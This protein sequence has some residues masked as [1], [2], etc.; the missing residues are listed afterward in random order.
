MVNTDDLVRNWLTDENTHQLC[1]KRH[2][3][4]AVPRRR[5]SSHFRRH[6]HG[7]DQLASLLDE[8]VTH[9]VNADLHKPD[10]EESHDSEPASPDVTLVTVRRQDGVEVVI[11]RD[12]A[13][14]TAVRLVNLHDQE[15]VV[16][17]FSDRSMVRLPADAIIAKAGMGEMLYALDGGHS[18]GRSR[19]QDRGNI[20]GNSSGAKIVSTNEVLQAPVFFPPHRFDVHHELVCR[21]ERALA[22][23]PPTTQGELQIVLPQMVNDREVHFALI[24]VNM[25]CWHRD[26]TG[27]TLLLLGVMLVAEAFKRHAAEVAQGQGGQQRHR[28]LLR[29]VVWDLEL[30]AERCMCRQ[31]R[32]TRTSTTMMG[33]RTRTTTTT[34]TTVLRRKSV[35]LVEEERAR[36]GG[37]I[38]INGQAEKEIVMSDDQTALADEEASAEKTAPPSSPSP[39]SAGARA[40][41]A[42]AAATQAEASE[43]VRRPQ[44]KVSDVIIA[45]TRRSLSMIATAALMQEVEEEEE[46]KEEVV[47]E[48]E[49]VLAA[50]TTKTKITAAADAMAVRRKESMDVIAVLAALGRPAVPLRYLMVT[51]NNVQKAQEKWEAT[52]KWRA[53]YR[54]DTILEAPHTQ[55]HFIKKYFPQFMAGRSRGGNPVYY[56]M[57]AK[58]DARTLV[59]QGVDVDEMI[60]HY[61]W[62]NEF[63]YSRWVPDPDGQIITVVDISGLSM[64]GM[65][66][67][68]IEFISRSLTLIQAHYPARAQVILLVNAPFFFSYIWKIVKGAADEYTSNT[69][70]VFS[71]AQ[72]FSALCEYI[73]PDQ[74]PVEY[75]GN[76]R[77]APLEGTQEW[78]K[79]QEMPHSVRWTSPLEREMEE[80]VHRVIAARKGGAMGK[81][82]GA[83]EEEV[84]EGSAAVGAA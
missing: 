21:V 38:I 10:E 39:S 54:A 81:E 50:T 58:I 83:E 77:Y 70:K 6:S 52:L 75:G 47:D 69:L 14:G 65:S 62:I 9:S 72:T 63:I 66:T 57:N 42:S 68:S 23:A 37:A 25:A 18:R 34:T 51:G 55:Y 7:V 33:T 71:T 19:S 61:V 80:H 16:F 64:S 29:A 60:W 28:Q 74:I 84:S 12:I 11:S 26:L 8:N 76:L 43:S 67:R 40:S 36:K 48:E 4:E 2:C 35:V 31:K 41:S 44:R 27:L 79:H 15:E 1:H 82:N 30:I 46:L 56:E 45:T 20:G 5:R 53:A 3:H 73:E 22:P 24:L 59:S 13:Y 17:T 49:G 32:F 78:A